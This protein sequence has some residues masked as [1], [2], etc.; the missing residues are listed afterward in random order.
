MESIFENQY[1]V[2]K[3]FYN[4]FFTYS[5]FKKPPLL[6]LNLL[7]AVGFIGEVV[8]LITGH[9]NNS[10]NFIVIV[11]LFWAINL[12]RFLRAK[13]NSIGSD[14]ETNNGKPH[15]VKYIVTNEGINCYSITTGA[16]IKIAFSLIKKAYIT[17]NYYVLITP[18]KQCWIF[19][20]DGFTKGSPNDFLPFLA[21]KGI[22]R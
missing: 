9:R 2:S 5:Y 10:I 7:L 4:E 6:F 19:K 1:T 20:K 12:I 21:S 14:F 17:K 3:D 18:S 8:F 13:K 15:E 16:D 22:R 11:P